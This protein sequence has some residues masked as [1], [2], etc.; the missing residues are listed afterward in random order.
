MEQYEGVT[1]GVPLETSNGDHGGEVKRGNT[2]HTPKWLLDI[3]HIH[4]SCHVFD[5]M[6]LFRLPMPGACSTT[7]NHGTSPLASA[8]VLPCSS[9]KAWRARP[10]CHESVVGILKK[11]VS[12]C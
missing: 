7:S 12:A 1:G 9:A 10:Y 11:C 3:I 4:A 8:G 2:A 6:L 5:G